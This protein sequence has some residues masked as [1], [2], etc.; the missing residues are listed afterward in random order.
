M[1]D[2]LLPPDAARKARRWIQIGITPPAADNRVH[3]YEQISDLTSGLTESN[4][5]ENHFFMHRPP[6]LR[7]RF[8]ARPRRRSEVVTAVHLAAAQWAASGL[9]SGWSHGCYEPETALFG[10]EV[11]MRFVH[12]MFSA[13][14]SV[15]LRH[16]TGS[17]TPAWL[18]ALLLTRSLLDAFRITPWEDSDVGHLIQ[19]TGRTLYGT[20]A[21]SNDVVTRVSRLWRDPDALLP[22]LNDAEREAVTS[23]RTLARTEVPRWRTEY[24]DTP[25]VTVGPRQL[26]AHYAVFMWNRARLSAYR[27]GL[28]AD[29]LARIA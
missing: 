26:I 9:V 12:R 5:I 18:V 10:G 2:D 16:H 15:W 3:L 1:S 13:D 21:T 24:F 17:R 20:T 4:R 19:R 14:S 22:E 7:L 23:F 11:S 8:E 27:Q 28:L 25:L 29:S 6:G